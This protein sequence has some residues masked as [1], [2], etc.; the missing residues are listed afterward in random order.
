M[1]SIVDD[2]LTLAEAAASLRVAPSTVRRWIREGRLPASRVGGR[3]LAIRRVDL[4]AILRPVS[5]PESQ[6]NS[7]VVDWVSGHRRPTPDEKRRAVEAVAAARAIHREFLARR[8]GEPFSP[9]WELIDEARDERSEQL[10]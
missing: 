7:P 10:G 1:A 5:A 2:H 6:W 9:S 3:R 8:G 4:A